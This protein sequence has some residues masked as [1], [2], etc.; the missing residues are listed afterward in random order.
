MNLEVENLINMALA[1]G[2]VTDKERAIILRKADALGLDK[3]EIEMILDGRIALMNNQKANAEQET[4]KLE[5]NKDGV[6]KKC[7]SCGAPTQSFKT[8]CQECAHEFRNT[9]SSKGIN[10]L[11][12]TIMNV[13][14]ED[15]LYDGRPA[16]HI[17]E[18]TIANIISNFPIPNSKEELLEFISMAYQEAIK[19]VGFWERLDSDRGAALMKRTWKSKCVQL[20]MKARFSLKDDK[21]TLQEIEYYAKQL[22][23]K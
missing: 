4:T 17:Y 5:S 18:Q 1:D 21:K 15:C 3:D 10:K 22:K 14:R 19:K 12:E 13:K 8:K 23:I 11:Y 7:P 9:D 6:V 20:I 2:V 16:E